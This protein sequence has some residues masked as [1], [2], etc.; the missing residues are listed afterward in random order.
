MRE[1][2]DVLLSVWNFFQPK[3]RELLPGTDFA[4]VDD[5]AH[6]EHWREF[7]WLFNGHVWHY[8]REAWAA[9][10]VPNVLLVF[11]EDLKADPVI[12]VLPRGLLLFMR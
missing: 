4:G 8:V 6:S 7:A 2:K 12:Q 11:Y 5:F 1:P 9:R 10:H 3:A